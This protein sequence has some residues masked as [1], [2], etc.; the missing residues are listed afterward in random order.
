M[1][2]SSYSRPYRSASSGRSYSDD[3]HS[4]Y[5]RTREAHRD[6]L[7][8]SDR[9]IWTEAK[10]PIVVALDGTGSMGDSAKIM[11]DKMPMF[12]GQIE[13]KGYLKDPAMSFAII[14]DENCD[15][16]PLQV[17]DFEQGLPIDNWLKKLWLEGGAVVR[18]WNHMIW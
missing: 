5:S 16:A 8:S 6:V 14:G 18:L 12:W 7:P 3:T 15:D 9:R 17:T 13:Q 11:F 1:G 2:G 4:Q 10:N